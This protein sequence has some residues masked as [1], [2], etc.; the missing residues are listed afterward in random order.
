TNSATGDFATYTSLGI[1]AFN[2]Y[3]TQTFTGAG[4]LS[5]NVNG[6]DIIK[7]NANGNTAYTI[8]AAANASIGALLFIN[9]T[10]AQ[11]IT[12]YASGSLT[13]PSTLSI[14][15]GAFMTLGGA[16]A[17]TVTFAGG[18]L[19]FG[20]AEAIFLQNYTGTA[21]TTINGVITGSGGLTVASV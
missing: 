4:T 11:A 9:G 10:G 20:S 16:T 21:A 5:A 8:T 12:L 6:A 15:S 1:A 14:N 17:A 13:S 3:N 2:N 7:V 18:T 19:Q